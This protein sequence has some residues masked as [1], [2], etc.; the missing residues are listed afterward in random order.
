MPAHT[1]PSTTLSTLDGGLTSTIDLQQENPMAVDCM[2]QLFYRLNY[3]PHEFANSP[4]KGP[5]DNSPR[6]AL[7]IHTLVHKLAEVYEVDDL[8]ALSLSKLEHEM[9]NPIDAV[10]FAKAMQEAYDEMH[11]T[12]SALRQAIVKGFHQYRRQ[13]LPDAN[14]KDLLQ[15]NGVLSYDIIVYVDQHGCY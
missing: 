13:L 6:P 10:D 1:K 15:S 7:Y 5:A 11:E 12:Y 2:M 14:I 3:D 4:A 9:A 8:K